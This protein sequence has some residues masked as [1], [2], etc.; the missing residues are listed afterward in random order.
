MLPQVRPPNAVANPFEAYAD[1]TNSRHII[2]KLL[3]FNKGDYL[4]GQG[5]EEIMI[6]TEMVAVMDYLMVGWI[7]WVDNAPAE[8]IMGRVVDGY[9]PPRRAE[10]GDND[11]SM[12][13]ADDRGDVRDPWQLSNYLV[14]V[15]Q[16]DTFTFTTSSKG[17]IG[18]VGELCKIYGRHM[19]EKPNEY[20]R[21]KLEVGS[22][23][24][25]DKQFGR[26]KFPSF[27]VIG[28]ADKAPIL[29]GLEAGE[30][31]DEEAGA[32][33]HEKQERAAKAARRGTAD[34]PF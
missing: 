33:D 11:Q 6:G 27:K 24:H 2:G 18:A 19:R 23:M 29:A 5:S 17:G 8:H 20:P 31:P 9:V 13:E 14:M 32:I 22:Y 7:K 21:I 25:S 26:I 15:G 16:D 28:W 30:Q 3:K 10:L 12:W 1:A 34:I 4:A